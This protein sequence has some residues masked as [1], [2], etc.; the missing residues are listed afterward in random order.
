MGPTVFLPRSNTS[1]AHDAYNW[2]QPRRQRLDTTSLG[3]D[4]DSADSSGDASEWACFLRRSLWCCPL[5]RRGDCVLFD[6]RLMHFAGANRSDEHILHPAQLPEG[7]EAQLP[8]DRRPIQK[9]GENQG[10]GPQEGMWPDDEDASRRSSNSSCHGQQKA[11]GFSVGGFNERLSG[12]QIA[13][14]GRSSDPLT[15]NS[16]TR[17]AGRGRRRVL[18]Y[19]SLRARGV[20][21]HWKGCGFDKPG[22]MLNELRGKF[23]IECGKAS[24]KLVS[25]AD[26]PLANYIE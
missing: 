22:T 19:F 18:F 5:L 15:V 12:Q 11:C 8:G 25:E 13:Q 14:E 6:S 16:M 7:R 20:G 21:A 3:E 1:N 26:S 10:A 4:N 23:R 17:S 24:W 2:G 9:L